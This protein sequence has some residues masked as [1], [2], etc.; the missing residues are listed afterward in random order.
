MAKRRSSKSS[1]GTVLRTVPARRVFSHNTNLPLPRR[2]F[3]LSFTPITDYRR[4]HPHGINRS[5]RSVDGRRVT[6]RYSVQRTRYRAP[7]VRRPFPLFADIRDVPVLPRSAVIC[8]RRRSRKEV[9][10]ATGNAGRR[11]Q[12]KPHRN[13]N[14]N[15]RCR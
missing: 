4:F 14:S 5:Y 15:L 13:E 7:T 3:A 10:F 1:N 12:R 11:G 2:L 6:P 8:A 9:M